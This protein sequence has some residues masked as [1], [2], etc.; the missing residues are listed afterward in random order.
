AKSITLEAL[1][2]SSIPPELGEEEIQQKLKALGPIRALHLR[3]KHQGL[4]I[5]DYY[6]LRHAKQALANIK[7][8][9]SMQQ[10]MAENNDKGKEVPS[11]CR[12]TGGKAMW[13]RYAKPIAKN[14]GTLVVFNL[15]SAISP[16]NLWS[17]IEEY[18]AV[19]EVR[20]PP[21]NNQVNFVEFCDVREA[22]EAKEALDEQEIGSDCI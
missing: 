1:L 15:D 17:T 9:H 10:K 12:L 21:L 6:D 2:L 5:V 19:K 8:K 20:E 13:A 4:V 7:Q 22:Y 11:C 18:G 16:D 3:R 14:Q